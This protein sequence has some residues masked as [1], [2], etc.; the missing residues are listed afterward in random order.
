MLSTLYIAGE[1]MSIN[2]TTILKMTLIFLFYCRAQK[3]ITLC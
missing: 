1:Q 3:F 2:D